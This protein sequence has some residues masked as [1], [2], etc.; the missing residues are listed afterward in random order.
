MG[1]GGVDLAK[2]DRSDPCWVDYLR[3]MQ[4]ISD[5]S[6]VNIT[7]IVDPWGRPYVIDENEGE[8]PNSARPCGQGKDYIGTYKRPLTSNWDFDNYYPLPFA[9]T[10]TTGSCSTL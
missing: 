3:A 2:L 9:N 1:R 7:N 10:Y 5:D 4:R 6:G 8:N